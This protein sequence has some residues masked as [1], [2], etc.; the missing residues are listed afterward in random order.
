MLHKHSLCRLSQVKKIVRDVK[1]QTFY[2]INLTKDVRTS[3]SEVKDSK[4]LI[5]SN[6]M[7]CFFRKL[8][9]T[10]R[11]LLHAGDSHDALTSNTNETKSL[12]KV[13]S[14]V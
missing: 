2:T 11:V 12:A 7:T 13:I 4:I 14:N 8:S 1:P 10:K 5:K 3:S 6:N 9:T